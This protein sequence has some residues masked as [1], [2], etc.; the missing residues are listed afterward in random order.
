[1]QTRVTYTSTISHV[2]QKLH[3]LHAECSQE[4]WCCLTI[5]YLYTPRFMSGFHSSRGKHTV[6]NFKT[7][8]IQ[9]KGVIPI[10]HV[11]I[12]KA[13]FRGGGRESIPR[14]GPS[15]PEIIPERHL[16]LRCLSSV[17]AAVP[18]CWP[19][20][21]SVT[22]VAFWGEQSLHTPLWGRRDDAHH[23]C[24]AETAKANGKYRDMASKIITCKPFVQQIV[25]P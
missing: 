25:H 24:V 14:V 15:S 6:V 19:Q 5:T 16:Q 21:E 23:N 4:S 9:S 22:S 10:L 18:A 8:Q 3:V 2:Q 11:H 13:T 17:K 12:G 20:L 1:M 7:G